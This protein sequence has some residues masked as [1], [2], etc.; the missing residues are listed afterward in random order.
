MEAE[1]LVTAWRLSSYRASVRR[2]VGDRMGMAARLVV[3]SVALELAGCPDVVQNAP[4]SPASSSS[5]ASSSYPGPAT[6]SATLTWTPPTENTDGAPLTNL[7]GYYVHYGTSETSLTQI[8]ELT[9]PSV[10]SFVV[11]DLTPGTYY[12]AV[13]AYDSLGFEGDW[14]NIASKT[15]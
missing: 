2:A 10:T 5:L 13:S 6:G 4:N 11:S 7:A 14:S 12:F 1:F 9:D 8:I 3:L 15:L